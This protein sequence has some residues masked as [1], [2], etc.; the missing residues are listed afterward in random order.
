M[1]L[2][3]RKLSRI[4]QEKAVQNIIKT[5]HDAVSYLAYIINNSQFNVGGWFAINKSNEGSEYW[6]ELADKQ[7]KENDCKV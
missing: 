2:D 3:F 5:D 1:N 7:R 6:M 4:D